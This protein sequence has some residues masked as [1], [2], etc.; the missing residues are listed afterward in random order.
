MDVPKKTQVVLFRNQA[1][2][3]VCH[4]L[5]EVVLDC[6]FNMGTWD[7]LTGGGEMKCL[8][9]ATEQYMRQR[10]DR[11]KRIYFMRSGAVVKRQFD[12]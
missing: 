2:E 7:F 10:N 9:E 5:L 1:L 6:S 11:D 8:D 4:F 3:M 12:L